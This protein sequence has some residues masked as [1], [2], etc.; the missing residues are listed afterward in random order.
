MAEVKVERLKA[1]MDAGELRRRI[2][3]LQDAMRAQNIDMLLA[4]N[5][6]LFYGGC[7]RYMT[8]TTAEI[9]YPQSTMLPVDG[10]PRY[11]AC[12]GPPQDLYPPPE[13]TLIG[14][15]Y[16]AAP[17]FSPFNYTNDWE[18]NF[19]ARWCSENG[20][21]KI[22]VAG[23]GMFYFNFYDRLKALAPELEIVDFS[24]EF[25]AIRAIK[26]D[27]EIERI[28]QTAKIQ[29]KIFSAVPAMARPGRSE[30]EIRSSIMQ[31][32]TDHGGE[33]MLT[34]VTSAPA[35]ERFELMPSFFQNRVLEEGDQLYVR[36]S[37]SGAG[38]YW[39]TLGRTFCVGREPSEMLKACN[40]KAFA[41]QDF[42]AAKL[43]PGADPEKIFEEYNEYL[44][45][46]GFRRETGLFAYGQGYDNIERPSVQPGE[47]MKIA[48]GMCMAV[49]TALNSDVFSAYCA[50]SYIITEAGPERLHLTPRAVVRA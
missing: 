12:S 42:L 27:I 46:G 4:Q 19:V 15:A 36:L 35:G 39:V 25:D 41:A 9:N 18:G 3:L 20:A 11:I 8:D 26:S 10:E 44:A 49:N 13:L 24:E 29:D 43:V 21:K 28:R 45:S 37:C 50:D 14:K 34:I 48:Q 33:E 16:D 30:E 6:T 5:I 38:G 22:G 23:Y 47:T 31:M 32:V 2:A 1:P 17:F 7:N 40:A